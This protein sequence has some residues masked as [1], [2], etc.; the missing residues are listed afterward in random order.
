M[1]YTLYLSTDSQIDFTKHNS[2]LV[3]FEPISNNDGNRVAMLLKNPNKMNVQLSLLS[4]VSFRFFENH[5]F[6][7]Y[8]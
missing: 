1:C 4:E 3:R 2:N 5:H 8:K 7:F 6:V